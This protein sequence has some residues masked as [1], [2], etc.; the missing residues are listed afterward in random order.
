MCNRFQVD[1]SAAELARLLGAV[2]TR[3]VIWDADIYPRRTAP[4]V[5]AHKGA[6]RLGP[7]TWGFPM[8]TAGKTKTVIKYVTNARHLDSAF[9]Q[10]SV[11]HPARRCLVPFTRFA[12]PKPGRDAEGQPAQYWFSITDQPVACFAGLWRPTEAGAVFAIATIEPNALVA[13]LHPK[14]MPVVLM[15]EDHDRWL[16]GTAEDVRQLQ[17]PYPSQL[18]SV[19]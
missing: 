12:E 4:V 3:E 19:A 18:M 14:A 7:M 10:P 9:W 5:I 11:T 17:A 15:R 2:V 13:P 16:T 8:Q 6:R 1:A